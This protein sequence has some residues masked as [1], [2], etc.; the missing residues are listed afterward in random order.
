VIRGRKYTD[1]LSM[2]KGVELVGTLSGLTMYFLQYLQLFERLVSRAKLG[3]EVIYSPRL[4]VQAA[5]R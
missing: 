4:S 5:R 1:K 2:R 3:P